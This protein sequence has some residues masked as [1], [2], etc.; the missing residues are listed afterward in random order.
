M[1]ETLLPV[2]CYAKFEICFKDKDYVEAE[3]LLI[4][5]LSLKNISFPTSLNAV[6]IYCDDFWNTGNE[7]DKLKFYDLL[8]SKF[9]K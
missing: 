7:N 2:I 5:L 3:K 8:V 1:M 6:Q 4:L 9:P